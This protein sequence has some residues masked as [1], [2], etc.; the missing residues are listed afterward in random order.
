MAKDN[1]NRSWRQRVKE[2][3]LNYL[4][5]VK[6]MASL[7]EGPG[8]AQAMLGLDDDRFKLLEE[9][10]NEIM[11]VMAGMGVLLFRP[12]LNDLTGSLK[13]CQKGKVDRAASLLVAGISADGPAQEG[14]A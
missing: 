12:R 9:L 7:P 13:L 1:G 3:N 2:L 4:H 5:L 10:N 14:E 6:E 8:Y 11:E